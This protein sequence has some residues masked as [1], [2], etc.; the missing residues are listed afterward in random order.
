HRRRS[1]MGVIRDSH[2]NEIGHVIA[3]CTTRAA[4]TPTRPKYDPMTMHR[5][6]RREVTAEYRSSCDPNPRETY[7]QYPTKASVVSSAAM[8]SKRNNGAASDHPGPRTK[9]TTGSASAA[10]TASGMPNV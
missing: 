10:A 5:I 1:G 3:G 4:A 7:T 8:A 6:L 2:A 9:A